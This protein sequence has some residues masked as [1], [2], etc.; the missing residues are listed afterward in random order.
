MT[1]FNVMS[2]E[3]IENKGFSSITY[4]QNS[5]KITTVELFAETVKHCPTTKIGCPVKHCLNHGN[6]LKNNDRVSIVFAS[7][8]ITLWNFS[9]QW[10]DE[11][12]V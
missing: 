2:I 8:C 5:N 9:T 3:V 4:T 11:E 6:L 7:I 10:K 12:W 1:Y